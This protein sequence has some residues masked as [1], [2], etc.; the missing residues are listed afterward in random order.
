MLK[1][2]D[3]NENKKKIIKGR[4]EVKQCAVPKRDDQ[5]KQNGISKRED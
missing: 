2:K 1:R 3:W 5:D 4:S